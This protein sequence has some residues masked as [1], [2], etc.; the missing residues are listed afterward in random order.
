MLGSTNDLDYDK[1]KTPFFR[2]S[3]SKADGSS[4]YELPPYLLG[5]VEKVEI[6]ES[7][8]GCSY[9]SLFHITFKEGSREPF[10][11]S[12]NTSTAAL[13][14][15]T[16]EVT[17]ATGMFTDLRF[18]QGGFGSRLPSSVGDILS[19]PTIPEV[20]ALPTG[21]SGK[22]GPTPTTI[23]R[24]GDDKASSS[25]VHYVFQERNKVK[26]TWG[27]LEDQQNQRSV[28]GDIIIIQSDFPEAG[29]PQVVVTCSGPGS[30]L[31]Q[32]A[33][34]TGIYFADTTNTAFTNSGKPIPTFQD[35][36][37]KKSI[38]KILEGFTLF[39]SDT[40]LADKVE[41]S[42]A[43]LLKGGDS[44]NQFL[45]KLAEETDSTY[46][47]YYS[48][49]TGLPAAAFISRADFLSTAII[50]N[51]ILTTYKAPG[52]LIKS[53]SVK[54]DFNSLSGAGYGGVDNSGKAISAH[55]GNAAKSEALFKNAGLVD[56]APTSAANPTKAAK[57]LDDKLFKSQ[58]NISAKTQ[59]NPNANDADYLTA[60]AKSKAACMGRTIFLEFSSLGYTRFTVGAI[61]FNGIGNRYSGLYEVITVTHTIDSSGYNCRGSAESA[62]I[63]GSTG[64]KLKNAK[65]IPPQPVEV[66]LVSPIASLKQVLPANVG[67]ISTASTTSSSAMADYLKDRLS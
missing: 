59:M 5:L 16:G 35:I 26:I 14:S 40:E 58:G 12:L 41:K 34:V 55:A 30:W 49:T 66:K 3:I 53:I 6:I 13:Y 47:T 48:P 4:T 32:L 33:P 21:A 1:Y 36:G 31:D 42:R 25:N 37:V 54:A 44:A 24:V 65:I 43:R 8:A 38:Q 10:N 19:S 28:I 39:I 15:E 46:I 11:K 22:S 20:P 9:T 63:S 60:K 62:S 23:I 17:N 2:I 61:N 27:Y 64:V 51:P 45:K 57:V 7:K 18:V 67:S 29:H 56:T 52:S 50:D